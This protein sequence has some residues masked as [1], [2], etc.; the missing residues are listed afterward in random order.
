VIIRLPGG[1]LYVVALT[2]GIAGLAFTGR[3]LDRGR[4]RAEAAG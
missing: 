1:V 4:L 2:I 3:G